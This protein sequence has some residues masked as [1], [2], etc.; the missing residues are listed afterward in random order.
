MSY[1]GHVA[2][3]RFGVRGQS[4]SRN[5]SNIS[6]E[7]LINTENIDMSAG[8]I[9]K[10]GG[11]S[12]Y[13]SQ[14]V[15][16]SI[17]ILGGVDYA[18]DNSTQRLV[19]ALSSGDVRMDAGTGKFPTV[20][21]AGRNANNRTFFT[22][23]GNES[24]GRSKKLFVC[25]GINTVMVVTGDATATRDLSQ[26]PADWT[27]S[28]QPRKLV[29]HRGRMW[30]W[31]ND[32]IYY[33]DAGN[34]EI[35][36]PTTGDAGSLSVWPGTG[37]IILDGISYKSRF[38]IL[39]QRFI[40][41]LDDS[42]TTKSNWIVEKL[43]D[44]LG[45]AGTDCADLIDDDVVFLSPEGGLHLLSAVETFGDIKNSDLAV[46]DEMNQ[47]IRD[48]VNFAQISKSTVKYYPAKK[49]IHV[50]VPTSNST[51][52]D[53]RLIVDMNGSV[54][55][56]HVSDRD[57]IISMWMYRDTGGVKRPMIGDNDGHVYR[58]DQ[59]GR[60][61][62][63]NGAYTSSFQTAH[64]DFSHVDPAL[65]NKR[66][67]FDF[68]ELKYEEIGSWYTPVDVYLDGQN[69]QR[70]DFRMSYG[71]SELGSFVLGTDALLG[72]ANSPPS[73]RR[74]RLRGS[75]QFFSL[76]PM[77]TGDSQEFLLSEARVYFTVADER[78]LR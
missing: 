14:D 3:I 70:V 16:N 47:W 53:K 44:S 38:F 25:N 54:P 57:T 63:L 13:T 65:A 69:T 58:L 30:G 46:P 49:Q 59:S 23:G 17:D 42:S 55:R 52:P 24:Q 5:Q 35:F 50:C 71:L 43:T 20:L 15:G 37:G 27:G 7:H 9:R 72:I 39:K 11:A 56:F 74:V 61:H 10:D 68:L 4:G 18:V 73:I 45:I 60:T 28:T 40:G 31:L 26:P 62:G 76:K 67:N 51:V 48:N 2:I 6:H 12:L 33:S 1:D 75:G 77:S 41:W 29:Q 66:K 22:E 78:L 21:A 36:H 8:I 64:T 32:R 34:H 19:I